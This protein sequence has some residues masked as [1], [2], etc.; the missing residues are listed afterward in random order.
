MIVT[1][2]RKCA[3]QMK[4]NIEVLMLEDMPR[5]VE[6]IQRDMPLGV[7]INVNSRKSERK[8]PWQLKALL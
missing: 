2:A 5:D 7:K 4:E 8:S 6:L 1:V 3:Y